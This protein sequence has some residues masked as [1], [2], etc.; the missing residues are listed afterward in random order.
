SCPRNT[1]IPEA[2]AQLQRQLEQFRSTQPKRAKLLESMAE[3][4]YRIGWWRAAT[5]INIKPYT[6]SVNSVLAFDRYHCLCS[7]SKLPFPQRGSFR[8]CSATLTHR[9][10]SKAVNQRLREELPNCE[11]RSTNRRAASPTSQR[12]QFWVPGI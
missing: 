11:W 5:V 3:W 4:K 7:N 10:G 12:R 2:I 6:A 9:G 1:R 8:H